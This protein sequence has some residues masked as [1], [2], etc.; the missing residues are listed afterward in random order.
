M[1]TALLFDRSS[2]AEVEDWSAQVAS[3]GRRSILWIDVDRPDSEEIR[4]IIESL[5][6]DHESA[7]RLTRV[8]GRPYFG[9]FENYL[10]V[11]AFVPARREGRIETVNVHCLVAEHWVVTV[12]EMQVEVFEEFRERVCGS[13]ETG[14]LDGPEFLADLLE[15]VLEAYLEAFEAVE[16]ALEEFDTK[17]M[18]EIPLDSDEQLR[19]LVEHR[20]EI[21]G[22]RRS[23]VAHRPMFFALTRPELEAITSS[24]HAE[25]FRELRRRLEM[26]VQVARDTR[27]S[28]VGSF[29]VML[30][31]MGQRTNE[32]VKVLTLGSMLLLPGALIAGVLGMNFQVGLF[33]EPAY[34]WVVVAFIVVLAVATVVAARARRWI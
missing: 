21:G 5:D 3:L 15:W 9:D 34:F 25:R 19:E 10:H 26:A 20:Q 13:G 33:E 12:H 27:E 1:A 30:A 6:L 24:E 29:D 7:S 14:R 2:F 11:T 23:L 28:V 22:L 8:D 18:G 32:I 17:A 4:E 16:L 31:M